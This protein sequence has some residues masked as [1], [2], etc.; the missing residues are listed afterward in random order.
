MRL[1]FAAAW[2]FGET[3]A[4]RISVGEEGTEPPTNGLLIIRYL[5]GLHGPQLIQGAVDAEPMHKACAKT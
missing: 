5:F 1:A 3:R 4:F 2:S